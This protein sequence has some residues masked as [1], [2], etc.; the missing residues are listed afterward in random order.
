VRNYP[1]SLPL[2]LAVGL[3]FCRAPGVS[4]ASASSDNWYLLPYPVGVSSELVQGNNGP[5]GHS[6]HAAFA[7]DFIMPIGSPVTA[8]RG[9]E[10]VKVERRFRDGTRTPGE[11]NY[12]FIRHAD[13]TFGRYYHLTT[14]GALIDSGA[15]VRRGDVIGRSGNSGTSAGPHLHFDVTRGCPTWGC[16]TVHI[17]FQNAGSD[18]LIAGKIYRADRYPNR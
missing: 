2:L 9:G 10:V 6:G 4:P 8:A 7:F 3:S 12:I 16:Q 13:G 15:R 18:S 14:G 11:E 5:W 17:V 1:R